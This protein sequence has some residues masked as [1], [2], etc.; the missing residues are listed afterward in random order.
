L[1]NG[2][3][4]EKT[5]CRT[6]NLPKIE[7]LF[8]QNI[9]HPRSHRLFIKLFGTVTQLSCEALAVHNHAYSQICNSRMLCKY[10]TKHV[11]YIKVSVINVNNDFCQR[12]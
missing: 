8:R 1:T 6:D 10:K 12:L 5:F 2:L 7:M 11:H 4:A 9:K 3:F